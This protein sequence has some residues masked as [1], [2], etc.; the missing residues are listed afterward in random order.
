MRALCCVLLVAI[1]STAAGEGDLP[2]PAGGA[3]VSD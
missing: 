2:L 1:V 3:K